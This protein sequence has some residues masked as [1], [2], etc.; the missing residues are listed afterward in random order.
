M[1]MTKVKQELRVSLSHVTGLFVL[2]GTCFA[3]VEARADSS[4]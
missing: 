1:P 3:A 4:A 2:L